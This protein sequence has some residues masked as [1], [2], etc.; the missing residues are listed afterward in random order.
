[1]KTALVTG[2]AGFIGYFTSRRLLD[3]GWRVI[4]LDA[5]SDYY[6]VALKER[7]Q[8]MLSQSAGFVPLRARL[9]DPGRLEEERRLAYVG[10]TRAQRELIFTLSKE[11]RQFGEVIQPEPSRF[12]YE[13]P[14]DDLEWEEKKRKVTAEERQQKGQASIANI[15]EM[16]GR[17]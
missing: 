14:T 16:L 6:E 10:I 1:M 7:R 13:L 5:F 17:S 8:A 11:R 9:E 2:S 15:R 3:Q 4:G 12:L